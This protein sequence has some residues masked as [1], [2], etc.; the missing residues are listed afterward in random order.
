MVEFLR[1]L[2]VV[3]I[4][5][6]SHQTLRRS[7]AGL[8]KMKTALMK[9]RQQ[10]VKMKRAIWQQRGMNT[11]VDVDII[12]GSSALIAGTIGDGSGRIE[13][14]ATKRAAHLTTLWR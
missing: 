5:H 11:S 3:K 1:L 14:T 9:W 7:N 2:R 8:M 10:R 4:A 12:E 6:V 13:F